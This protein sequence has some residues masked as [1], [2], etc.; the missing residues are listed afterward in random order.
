MSSRREWPASVRH[1]IAE[2]DLTYYLPCVVR[3]RTIAYLGVSR[4]EE[5]DFLSSDDLELL[6]TL[7]GYVGIAIENARLYSSLQQKVEEY[8]RLKEFSENIVESINVG[9]LAAD[10]HDRVESW[11]SQIEKLTGIPRAGAV[12]TIARRS[13]PGELCDQFDEVKGQTGIHNIYKVAWIQARSLVGAGLRTATEYGR[14]AAAAA[15]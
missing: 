6:V 7:S 13:L 5:G 8:E 9:I 2:L 14:P 4:T 11:N 1:T 10:L 12:G 3:G 15:R